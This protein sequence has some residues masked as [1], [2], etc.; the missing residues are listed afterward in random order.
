MVFHLM[1]KQRSYGVVNSVENPLD[2]RALI[3]LLKEN[4]LSSKSLLIG[5]I[6]VIS[7]GFVE[8]VM[9]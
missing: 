8:I 5:F 1:P 2:G 7:L 6:F 4:R 3:G 9:E